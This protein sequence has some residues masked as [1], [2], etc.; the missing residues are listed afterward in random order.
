MP[1]GCVTGYPEVGNF[2]SDLDDAL[3][4]ATA[5]MHLIARQPPN[6]SSPPYPSESRGKILPSALQRITRTASIIGTAR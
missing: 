2:L 6:S 5:G 1:S 4:A 3:S